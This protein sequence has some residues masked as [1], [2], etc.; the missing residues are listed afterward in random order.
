MAEGE[1]AV[2]EFFYE[3]KRI[4]D[5]P[6]TADELARAKRSLIGGFA[7]TLE[8]AD[9]AL[10]RTLERIQYNL[11]PDYWD[12]YAGQIEAVTVDDVQR[13]AQKYIG[14]NRIQLIAVGERSQIEA[15]LKKFGPVTSVAPTPPQRPISVTTPAPK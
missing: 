8:S 13:V 12:S 10:S 3:F 7:R 1:A 2:K 6:V 9:N 15:G 11:S 5:K 4:Q 14:A